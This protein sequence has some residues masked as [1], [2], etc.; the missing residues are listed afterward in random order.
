MPRIFLT[1]ARASGK[2]S[3]GQEL[4]RRLQ[5]PFYDLDKC[6]EEETGQSIAAFVAQKGWQEFRKREHAI[7]RKIGGSCGDAIIATG[8]GIVLD[9]SNRDYMTANGIAV[10]LNASPETMAAR[11]AACPDASQRPSL[12]GAGMLE[13]IGQVLKERMPL[14]AGCASCVVDGSQDVNA[15]CQAICSAL[16]LT[17]QADA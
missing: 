5:L 1:G 13:E 7:L 11:L 3:V 17:A 2:S 15:A 9:K 6:F 8:G 16:K 10:W 14:Y 4:A 12:T